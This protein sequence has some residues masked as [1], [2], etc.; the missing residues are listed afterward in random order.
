[1][2]KLSLILCIILIVALLAACKLPDV[3]PIIL[4]NSVTLNQFWNGILKDEN[5]VVYDQ[6]HS[7]ERF[8]RTGYEDA[9]SCIAVK[10]YNVYMMY[11]FA[12]AS[13][14]SDYVLQMLESWNKN[15][16]DIDCIPTTSGIYYIMKGSADNCNICYVSND[17]MILGLGNHKDEQEIRNTIQDVIHSEDSEY[18]DSRIQTLPLVQR[19]VSK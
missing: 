3:K 19:T 12:D 14:T 10:N 16:A 8:A 13:T 1:M 11:N 7:P 6:T 9:V 2:K 4:G 15:K 5:A 18:D 17:T